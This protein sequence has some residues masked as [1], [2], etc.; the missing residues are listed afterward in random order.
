MFTAV[1]VVALYEIFGWMVVLTCNSDI[2]LFLGILVNPKF[3][4]EN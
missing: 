1:F 4:G 3:C 2:Y